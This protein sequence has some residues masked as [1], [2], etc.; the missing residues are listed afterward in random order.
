MEE[1]FARFDSA[2]APVYPAGH[3]TAL[4]ILHDDPAF[5]AIDKPA[6]SVVH[7]TRGAAG[8]L[9]LRDRLSE[10]LGAEVFPVHR[11]DC[12]TSGV[13]VFAK[14]ASAAQVLSS[15]LCEGRWTKRYLA[16]CRGPIAAEIAVDRPVPEDGVERHARTRIVPIETFCDRFTLVA[17]LPET[18]RRHQIRF[19]LKQERHHV[20]GD[21]TYGK[22][23][24]NR[25][26]R[27]ELGLDR[28][29]LHASRLLVV[30]P[31]RAERIEILSPLPP[32][33]EAV[34]ARL[35]GI[36]HAPV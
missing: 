9:V 32:D 8:V 10:Q 29:F 16:L 21:T 15:D 5:V 17:A 33:L 25:W 35:R 14:G 22:G 2:S 18:G 12:Q 3:V 1:L 19:H 13:L 4:P 24:I 30:H 20:V 26:F 6:W 7:R 28:M 23:P 31:R 36:A 27:A 34:L 11:L